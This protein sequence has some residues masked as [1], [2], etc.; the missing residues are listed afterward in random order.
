MA[1]TPPDELRTALTDARARIHT[2]RA[3]AVGP[4]KESASAVVAQIDAALQALD[5]GAAH[6]GG[7]AKRGAGAAPPKKDLLSIICHDLK[8]PLASIVMG[9]GFLRKVIPADEQFASARRIIEA[10]SRSS[11]RMNRVIGDFYDLGKLEGGHITID[12]QPHDAV[13]IARASFDVFTP[14]AKAKS[15]SLDFV[16]GGVGDAGGSSEPLLVLCDRARVMQVI[17]KILENAIKFTPEGGSITLA[18]AAK[19]NDVEVSVKDSGR[20]I[21]EERRPTVFNREANWMA[22]PRDG[23]GLGLAI[24]KGFMDLHGGAI[25]VSS[26][27]TKG[28][29]F[30]FT[31]PRR[32][33]G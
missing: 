22:T 11:D 32:P 24:A 8:D 12:K 25:G 7:A 33:A 15:I 18:V 10:I 19:G 6:P 26:E 4:A 5:D 27:P 1:E 9:A 13:A 23:P 30:W 3:A 14:L 31:L 20:G 28:A 2:A 16:G 21:T 29:R 17:A